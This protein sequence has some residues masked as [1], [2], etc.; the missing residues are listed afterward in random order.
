MTDRALN[1]TKDTKKTVT[2][3]EAVGVFDN[4]D[5]LHTAIDEL[6]EHGFMRQELSVL[7][8]DKVVEEKLHRSYKRTEEAIDDP[9]APRTIFVPQETLG[10]A[11]GALIGTPLYLAATTAGAVT[12]AS[13]GTIL[14][15]IAAA[16]AAGAAGTAIGGVLANF[17]SQHH[18]DYIQD[19]LE[20]GGIVLWVHLRSPEMQEKARQI[21]AKHTNKDVHIHE[22]PA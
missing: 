7:A 11:E 19:Q 20:K 16:A 2:V 9:D 8:E 10:E 13:G 12:V 14:T 5:D 22:I 6:Q 3:Q 4:E 17:L 15:A 1:M 18:A 21:L